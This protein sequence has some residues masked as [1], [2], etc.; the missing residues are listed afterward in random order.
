MKGKKEK[1]VKGKREEEKEKIVK[2]EKK[3]DQKKEKGYCITTSL[4]I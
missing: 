3:Q 1:I 2:G 4:K